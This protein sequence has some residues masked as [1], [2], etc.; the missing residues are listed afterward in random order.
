MRPVTDGPG[1]PGRHEACLRPAMVC[2]GV[3]WFPGRAGPTSPGMSVPGPTAGQE[4]TRRVCQG[5]NRAE[6]SLR[7]VSSCHRDCRVPGTSNNPSVGSRPRS[8][9]GPNSRS[10]P[11]A[12][13]DAALPRVA[14]QSA[15]AIAFWAV[16]ADPPSGTARSS[17]GCLADR[18]KGPKRRRCGRF[19]RNGPDTRTVQTWRPLLR[20]L[21]PSL[22]PRWAIPH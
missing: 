21:Q 6:A 3:R 14:E 22:S 17:I 11:D 18:A 13:F 16:A 1:P 2:V 5:P 20:H 15:L 12:P 9:C 19:G 4:P 10:G 8:S 7:F